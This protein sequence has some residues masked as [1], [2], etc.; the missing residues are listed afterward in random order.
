MK[1]NKFIRS[2]IILIIGGLITKAVT[3]VPIHAKIKKYNH[4]YPFIILLFF[5]ITYQS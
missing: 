4:A 2:S 1:K 5:K 3:I